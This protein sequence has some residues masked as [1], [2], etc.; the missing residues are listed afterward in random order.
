MSTQLPHDST[1]EPSREGNSP[2]YVLPLILFAPDAVT[3]PTAQS[4]PSMENR[5]DKTIIIN[6]Y[7]CTPHVCLMSLFNFS[8]TIHM[9]DGFLNTL[10]GENQEDME[11][12]LE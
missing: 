1:L 8:E 11:V 5:Y 10:T 4:F 7:Y 3:Q 9:N 2:G 12:P 6:A